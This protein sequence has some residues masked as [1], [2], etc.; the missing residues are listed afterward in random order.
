MVGTL[1]LSGAV[2]LK[3]GANVNSIMANGALT[4]EAMLVPFI[5]QAESVINVATNYNWTDNYAA[6]NA[7]VKMI[8]EE[9][10][11]NLAAMYAIQYDMSGYSSPE[12]VSTMLDVLHDAFNRSIK[13]LEDKNMQGFITSS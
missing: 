4:A 6:L 3:A 2:I 13:L 1:C 10:A 5:N 12:E 7:D 8:L 9:A 11:S